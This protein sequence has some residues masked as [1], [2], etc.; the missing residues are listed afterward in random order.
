MNWSEKRKWKK[1][2]E[3]QRQTLEKAK[4]NAC[5]HQIREC[6]S[7]LGIPLELLRT[8]IWSTEIKARKNKESQSDKQPTR[9]KSQTNTNSL[10]DDWDKNQL[11]KRISHFVHQIKDRAFQCLWWELGTLS[12]STFLKQKKYNFLAHLYS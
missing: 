6:C 1:H 9:K 11:F 8:R 7:C 4:T 10:W 12:L 2:T 5:K 3:K